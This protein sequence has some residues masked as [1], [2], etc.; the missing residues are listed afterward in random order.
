MFMIQAHSDRV[1]VHNEAQR[2]FEHSYRKS[3]PN[4]LLQLL[5]KKVQPLLQLGQ[6]AE[7]Y[8]SA[9]RHYAGMQIVSVE[10]IHGTVSRGDDFDYDFHPRQTSDKERWCRVANAMIRGIPLPAIEL[11]Q[12][13]DEYFVKDGHHRISVAR[14]MD[15]IYLDA[16]VEIWGDH[17]VPNAYLN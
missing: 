6:I 16:L 15:H 14:A 17:D 5:G 8:T 13:G 2:L 4:P 9:N 11:I 7:H 12:V 3:K 10:N 1:A